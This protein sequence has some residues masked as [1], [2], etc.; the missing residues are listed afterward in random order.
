MNRSGDE[1][2]REYQCLTHEE[3]DSAIEVTNET[4]PM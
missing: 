4:E 3:R 2:P 1:G